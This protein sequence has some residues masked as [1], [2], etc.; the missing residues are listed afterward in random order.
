LSSRLPLLGQQTKPKKTTE[1]KAGRIAEYQ[2]REHAR[3][4]ADRERKA[5]ERAA[6]GK[7]PKDGKSLGWSMIGGF[8]LVEGA[9]QHAV[10]ARP[11][12]ELTAGQKAAE[13]VKV[14]V[15]GAR[16]KMRRKD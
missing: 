10:S 8:G 1:D 7:P 14:A 9:Q 13:A 5:Y 3:V 12:G 2:A 6:A 15:A 11:E 4:V 16:E